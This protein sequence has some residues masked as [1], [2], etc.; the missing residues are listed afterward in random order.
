MKTQWTRFA[1]YDARMSQDIS[2]RL[3]RVG[4][5]IARFAQTDQQLHEN[6]IPNRGLAARSDQ[7]GS[8]LPSGF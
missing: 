2:I 3:I 1:P 5:P 6:V 8:R 4:P 7:F